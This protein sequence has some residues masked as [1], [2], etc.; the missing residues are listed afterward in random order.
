MPS[1]SL[2]L[3]QCYCVTAHTTSH[4]NTLLHTAN[5]LEATPCFI[6]PGMAY[7]AVCTHPPPTSPCTP[8][9]LRTWFE[10]TRDR[11]KKSFRERSLFDWC[12]ALLPCLT[13]LR[14]YKIKEFLVVS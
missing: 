8:A 7:L 12:A 5:A 1:S 11:G 14:T 10:R 9:G 3:H 13:W 4:L 6:A 2:A